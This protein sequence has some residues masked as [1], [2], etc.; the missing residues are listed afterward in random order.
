M[1]GE[2]M[3][4]GMGRRVKHDDHR[5]CPTQLDE[6]VRWRML[7][8]VGRKLLECEEEAQVAILEDLE[9]IVSHS[10]FHNGCMPDEEILACPIHDDDAGL[11]VPETTDVIANPTQVPM[12]WY[13]RLDV[14]RDK[15]NGKPVVA[16]YVETW[17]E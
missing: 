6:A 5:P 4:D 3:G 17:R 1:V 15:I 16:Y 10:K 8:A 2:D 7:A 14:M 11:K 12:S 9:G 13:R